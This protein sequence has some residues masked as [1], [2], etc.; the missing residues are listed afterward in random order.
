M[1]ESVVYALAFVLS[2]GICAGSWVYVQTERMKQEGLNYRE[3]V[4]A[5]SRKTPDALT[6][7]S[8]VIIA[9]LQTPQGQ[10]LA[11]K[12]FEGLTSQKQGVLN[13]TS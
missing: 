12:L 3:G 9:F 4:R 8:P 1:Y 2:V 7:L 13:G 10:Q 11:G 6:S 5:E